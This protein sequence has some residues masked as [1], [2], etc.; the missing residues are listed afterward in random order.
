[1]KKAFALILCVSLLLCGCSAAPQSIKDDN[2][3]VPET[4]KSVWMAYF[5]L[6]KYTSECAD[7]NSFE[8]EIKSAFKKVKSLGLN[9]ITVQVRP[10]ADA[11]YKSSYFPVSKYC[12][13]VQGSE[14]IYDPLAIMV[15]AAHNLG[16]RI[17]AW[18]KPYRVSQE[19]DIN[20]LSSGNPAKKWLEDTEKSSCV[21][22]ADK[23]YFNPARSEVTELIVNGVKEI[24]KNYAVDGIHF[25]DYFYPTTNEEIDEKEYSQ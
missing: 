3:V 24:V 4:V 22:V 2:P 12:F 20:A 25:D 9:T 15:K 11:F 18:V 7:S 6:E 19:N 14:L 5:E 23:I 16:L 1:M 21:Y 10:C 13:G 8:S 17:E